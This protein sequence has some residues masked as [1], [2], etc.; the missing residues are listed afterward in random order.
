M[1][2]SPCSSLIST[3]NLCPVNSQENTASEFLSCH[4]GPSFSLPPTWGPS[5][6]LG[7]HYMDPCKIPFPDGPLH[8]GRFL[9]QSPSR[10]LR[11]ALPMLEAGLVKHVSSLSQYTYKVITD[12]KTSSLGFATLP[13]TSLQMHSS[14]ICSTG[15]IKMG[16]ND[17]AGQ[18]AKVLRSLK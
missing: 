17:V 9:G 7:P 15:D 14:Y 8:G 6:Y 10:V 18:P 1:T 13:R 3:R 16:S 11:A 2:V 4:L 5:L 12:S